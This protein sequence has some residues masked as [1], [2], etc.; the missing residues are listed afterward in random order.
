MVPIFVFRK[1]S[2]K[3]CN[4]VWIMPIF[5]VFISPL[6][7]GGFLFFYL[8]ILHSK[9]LMLLGLCPDFLISFSPLFLGGFKME[10]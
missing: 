1:F 8:G 4:T 10:Y 6:F 9:F 3:V 7:L 2:F 5:V